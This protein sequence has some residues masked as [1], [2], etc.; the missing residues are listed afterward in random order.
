MSRRKIKRKKRFIKGYKVLDKPPKNKNY[1][2]GM[3]VV[4]PVETELPSE[5]A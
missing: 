1:R 2:K 3:Y 4:A 5:S